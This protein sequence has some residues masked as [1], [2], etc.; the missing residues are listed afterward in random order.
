V[1]HAGE[2]IDFAFVVEK[3]GNDKEKL[4]RKAR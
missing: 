3:A 2:I 1:I 4:S